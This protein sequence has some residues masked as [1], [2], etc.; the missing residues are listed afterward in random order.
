MQAEKKRMK[1]A[2]ANH[3][4]HNHKERRIQQKAKEKEK[5]TARKVLLNQ[6]KVPGPYKDHDRHGNKIKDLNKG[7]YHVTQYLVPDYSEERKKHFLSQKSLQRK[8]NEAV[9][10]RDEEEPASNLQ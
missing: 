9:E 10:E 5:Q 2:A 7:L 4:H 6:S 8:L 3:H 1:A